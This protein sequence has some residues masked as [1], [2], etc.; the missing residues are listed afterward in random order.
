[1]RYRGSNIVMLW[2]AAQDAGYSDNRWAT[3]RQWAEKGASV[4]KG[5]KGTPVLWFQMLDRKDGADESDR[6]LPCARLSWVFNV[7]QIDG[8]TA[9]AV[10]LENQVTPVEQADALLTASGASITHGGDSA[11]YRPGTDQI[12]LPHREA[13]TGTTTMTATEA[14]Y[15]TACHELVHWTGSRLQRDLG[16]RFGDDAYAA[17]E[18]VAE[19]GAAFL[20]AT[21]GISSEPRMDHVAY[22]AH[23]S[24]MLRSDRRAFVTA[25]S[26]ASEACD[27]LLAFLEA[28]ELEQAA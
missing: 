9:D 19:L 13:F 20:C 12:V 25:A 10:Q 22:L 5:E 8:Y 23:W 7:A 16:K 21:L 3:F 2:V 24:R 15:A 4:R 18:L 28:E 14:Y 27:F 6:K 26:K 1:R 11:Y 17:E